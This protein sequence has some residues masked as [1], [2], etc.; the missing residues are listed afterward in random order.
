MIEDTQDVTKDNL[1]LTI[2]PTE[3]FIPE[4]LFNPDIIGK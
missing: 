3:V 4:M 1:E 2:C